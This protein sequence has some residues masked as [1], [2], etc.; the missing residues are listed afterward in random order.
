MLV[1]HIKQ[2]GSDYSKELERIQ[3][4]ESIQIDLEGDEDPS[5]HKKSDYQISSPF[6]HVH[7]ATV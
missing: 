5:I 2:K 4:P 6:F 7:A 3:S 1:Y